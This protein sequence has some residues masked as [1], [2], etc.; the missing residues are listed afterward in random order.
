MIVKSKPSLSILKNFDIIETTP[1][2]EVTNEYTVNSQSRRQRH[3][4]HY[5]GVYRYRHRLWG[6]R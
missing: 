3:P 1:S 2:W 6:R 4:P 5:A